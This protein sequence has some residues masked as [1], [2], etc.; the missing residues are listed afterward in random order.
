MQENQYQINFSLS[1]IH[2]FHKETRFTVLILNWWQVFRLESETH[3]C[4]GY[5]P[6]LESP[7]SDQNVL[8]CYWASHFTDRLCLILSFSFC[9]FCFC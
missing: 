5:A 3:W 6:S 4:N 8:L 7:S 1:S 2:F 9:L